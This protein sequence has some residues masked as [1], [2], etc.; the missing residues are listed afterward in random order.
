[1]M[2][3]THAYLLQDSQELDGAAHYFHPP[4][5]VDEHN[6]SVTESPAALTCPCA[7]D[8]PNGSF[9]ALPDGTMVGPH[10]DDDVTK[11]T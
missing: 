5:T 10:S 6:N 8:E 9:D 11:G 7:A 4:S 1:M 2:R 3:S